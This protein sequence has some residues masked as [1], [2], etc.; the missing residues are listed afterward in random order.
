MK[1]R[2]VRRLQPASWLLALLVASCASPIPSGPA[3]PPSWAHAP[4]STN[5]LSGQWWRSFGDP[6]LGRLIEEAW[7]NNPDLEVALQRIE[8]ARADR[9]EAMA[10]LYPSAGVALGFRQGREQDRTTN[11]RPVD[12]EPWTGE[13]QV[14]WEPDLTGRLGARLSAAESGEAVAYA[15]WQGARLLVATEV[16][17]ARFEDLL[18]ASEI[19]RQQAQLADE[20]QAAKLTA[21]LL[22]RGL[23]SS[24]ENASTIAHTE[25]LDREIT[26][27]DR[28]RQNARVRLTR[29]LGGARVPDTGGGVDLPAVPHRVPPA[30]WQSR[31]DLIAAEAGVRQ[32]FALGDAARLDLLPSLRFG[33]GASFGNNSLTGDYNMWKASVG[34]SLEI[35]I[36]APDRIAAVKRSRAQALAAAAGFRSTADKAIEEIERAY[37]NLTRYRSQVDSLDR[38]TAAHRR[39]WEDAKSKSDRG[40]ESAI[41]T[42]DLARR[43]RDTAALATRTKLRA[44]TAHLQLIRALGG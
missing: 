23:V 4:A 33:A 1:P 6:A 43:Y 39:A 13:A 35:P 22:E 7:K 28:V 42:T 31:P 2:P 9:F 40:L 5:S 8:A 41:T 44:L 30:V 25:S 16:A 17:A 32:A 19:E 18:L 37:I 27:L 10:A 29:L 11:M 38:E 12:L 14:S 20:R 24:A 15:R 26:E 34:P 36:W 21:E 3:P